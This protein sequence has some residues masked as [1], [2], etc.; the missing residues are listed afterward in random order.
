MKKSEFIN[1][2]A[3]YCEFEN[4]NFTLNTT[5]KSIEGFDSLAVMSI[6]AFLD[7]KFSM[8]L[9]AVKLFELKDFKSLMAAIGTDKFEND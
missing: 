8:K 1:Q 9:T 3:E 2:L 7:E 6:I 5:F 4:N